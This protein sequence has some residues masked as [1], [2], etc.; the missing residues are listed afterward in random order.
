MKAGWKTSEFWATVGA[1]LVPILNQAF[2]WNLPV[3][4][5]AM[6]CANVAAYVL[7]RSV[8]KVKT[9]G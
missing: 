2:G 6:V 3:D 5:I 8:V 4:V 1:A 7:G 9:G